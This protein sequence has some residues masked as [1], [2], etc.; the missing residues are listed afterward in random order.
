[1]S[2]RPDGA[3]DPRR[4]QLY[5]LL[6]SVRTRVGAWLRH[7]Q[8][9]LEKRF[10]ALARRPPVLAGILVL[11]ALMILGLGLAIDVAARLPDP[12]ALSSLDQ[13]SEATLVYDAFDRPAFTIFREQRIRV[14]IE[15]MS[16]HLIDAVLA[17]E[18]RRFYQHGGIDLVRVAGATVANLTAGRIVEGGSTI[19]QQLARKGLL[20]SERTI[21]RKLA[22]ILTALWIEHV[23]EKREI[24]ELYLNKI[25]FGSGFYGAETAA[26]G[27]LGKTAA[28][29][30]VSDAALLAGL[31]QAPERYS[32]KRFP[33]RA[34]ARR[35]VVLSVMMQTNVIDERAYQ[36]ARLEPL[37]LDNTLETT[38]AHGSYF[39]EELRQHLIDVFGWDAVYEEGLRVYS[40][41]DPEMQRVAEERL[42]E[43]IREIEARRNYHHPR[44]ETDGAPETPAAEPVYLQ[45]ALIALDPL[46]GE[47][48]ALVGGRDFADSSFNRAT[49]A[50][51]QPGSAFKPI[52]YAAA[53]DQGVTPIT[54]LD[55]LDHP[56]P[57]DEGEWL[58]ADGHDEVSALTVREAL[59][60]SSNRAAVRLIRLTGIDRAVDY[61]ARFGLGPQPRV[62]SVALGS[63]S[64]T[65]EALTAAYA[66]FANGG[67][68]PQP[69]YIRRVT[70][71]E[72]LVLFEAPSSGARLKPRAVKSS[73]AF[74]MA[75]LLRGVLDAGTG[76]TVRREG[77]R[78]PAAGKTGT[79]DDVKDAW[80]IGFTPELTAGVWIGF[81]DPQTIVPRGFGSDLAAPVW[82]RFMSEVVEPQSSDSW[83]EP[84]P[85]VVRV[86]ICA[87]SLLVATDACRRSK[88]DDA[89]EVHRAPT[90]VEYFASGSEPV[91]RCPIHRSFLASVL[92]P[93]RSPSRPESQ[94]FAPWTPPPEPPP[95]LQMS[96]PGQSVEVVH[97]HVFGNCT[98]LLVVGPHGL[99]YVTAHKDA[100]TLDFAEIATVSFDVEKRRVR[101]SVRGG[102]DYNFH[103]GL[104]DR[105][106]LV[107][108]EAALHA[109]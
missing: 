43:G 3:R 45:G 29:L 56:V 103:A 64:V 52:L 74:V 57:S 78:G 15:R 71:G 106:G 99:R 100:F 28:E 17:I 68:V 97:D 25:Y 32:P 73:T 39:K 22:E 66:A 107:A 95:I 109:R 53:L 81:D 80:F 76:W 65:L 51:R 4:V 69:T 38:E 96:G 82:A 48:R 6:S 41:I 90:Y 13:M 34:L 40:T 79:T 101:I 27:Y 104:D 77:F 70:D 46:S 98:G 49:Q 12:R 18:D 16:P 58:P 72:G 7:A 2:E 105:D 21:R 23:Y 83:I 87:S 91:D 92:A 86:E 84:P 55:D 108:L 102:R 59:Q 54:M 24:L 67:T 10:P 8:S 42:E 50:Q 88:G 33:E 9:S 14:P 35:N 36:A 19:T 89:G 61:A 30:S 63:G 37:S 11:V 85:E 75:S 1:M 44:R 94:R 26:R 47:V 31:I 60:M 62:P 5:A 20:S 93:F